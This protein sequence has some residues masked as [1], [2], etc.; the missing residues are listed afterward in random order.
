MRTQHTFYDTSMG[1]LV[2]CVFI[3]SQFALLL[4]GFTRLQRRDK[5]IYDYSRPILQENY[6]QANW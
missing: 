2:D 4:P 5:V 1:V 3:K 6:I